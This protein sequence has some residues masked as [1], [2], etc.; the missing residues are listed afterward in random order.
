MSKLLIFELIGTLTGIPLGVLGSFIFSDRFRKNKCGIAGCRGRT[1]KVC[2]DS[3]CPRHCDEI[4]KTVC[5]GRF[6]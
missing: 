1:S 6:L 2:V 5:R 4:H 3:L